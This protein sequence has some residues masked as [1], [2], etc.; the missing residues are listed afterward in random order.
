MITAALLLALGGLVE[1]ASSPTAVDSPRDPPIA[2]PHG[3]A[4]RLAAP[5]LEE[6]PRYALGRGLTFTTQDRRF[7]LSLGLGGQFLYTID[8]QRPRPRGTPQTSQMLEVRR[9]RVFLSG[10][11]FT[12]AVK[13]YLQ[14]QLSP[15][16]LGLV[17]GAVRQ[18]PVF[19]AWLRFERFGNFVPQVGFFFIPYS[20]QRVEPVLKLQMIDFSLASAEFGLERDVGVDLGSKDLFGLGK[21]RYHL[22]VFMGEGTE[23]AKPTDF[24]MIYYGR[25]ELL[26][27][28]DFDDD[29]ESDLARR[30]RPKLALGGAYAFA[31]DDHRSKP[32]G[33]AAPSDGGTTDT[34]NVTV[35]LAF[36]VAGFSL[37]ADAWFRHGRREWGDATVTDAAGTPMPAPREAARNG[38]GWT[39]QAGFLIPRAPL[40]L[41]ARYSGVHGLGTTS[42]A[43]RSEAGPGLSYYFADH[44]LKLQADFMHSW[45]DGDLRG[46]R[47]RVQLTFLF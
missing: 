1:A 26:P 25:F 3:E 4:A 6:R 22:G 13:Y 28:G 44:A 45:G 35:D 21:L 30:R 12:E 23:F 33:G 16:D 11:M 34:H 43:D 15:R 8:D 42:I 19:Q 32:I 41:A 7:S 14:A 36:K 2:R 20:R 46:D 24:G 37:L 10:N 17:D 31:D 47:V 27:L 5:A 9:M 40:E 18:S 29:V 38:V 39:A